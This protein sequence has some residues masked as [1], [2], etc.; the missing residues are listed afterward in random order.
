MRR[1]KDKMA[2]DFL[3]DE[4]VE[5]EIERLKE[6]PYVKLAKKEESIRYRR[7]QYLY[8]LK[9]YEKKGQELSEAGIT[10]EI[11]NSMEEE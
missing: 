8:K 9:G 2:R 5:Q 3:T 6:S 4:Q 10:M 7:R 1:M 11:L